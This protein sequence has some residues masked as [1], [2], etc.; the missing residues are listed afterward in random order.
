M[1]MQN[2]KLIG[3][4][5]GVVM[6]IVG[7]IIGIVIVNVINNNENDDSVIIEG[8][9]DK[10]NSELSAASLL[11]VNETISIYHKYID[12]LEG[13]EK[14]ELLNECAGYV[15]QNDTGKDYSEEVYADLIA[16]DEILEST[17]SAIGVM[18]A[19]IF[20]GNSD[21]VSEYNNIFSLRGGEYDFDVEVGI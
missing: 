5:I 20:Y 10:M 17:N 7:L 2:K 18:N 15:I 21:L 9:R 13:E 6:I 8:W 1:R 16:A 3:I 4:L 11:G 19:G 14:A 12:E